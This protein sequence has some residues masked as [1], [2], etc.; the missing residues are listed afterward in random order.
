MPRTVHG[1]NQAH[2]IARENLQKHPIEHV[3]KS[4]LCFYKLTKSVITLQPSEIPHSF[5]MTKCQLLCIKCLT[6]SSSVRI[7]P[8]FLTHPKTSDVSNLISP[9]NLLIKTHLKL[10]MCM[11]RIS[12][13]V[14]DIYS[15]LAGTDKLWFVWSPIRQFRV[16]PIHKKNKTQE[17]LML[18]IMCQNVWSQIAL[19][20]ATK[21]HRKIK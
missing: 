10:S 19:L 14:R 16:D 20:C 21:T 1:L 12:T 17:T 11:Y 2:E 7:V 8:F 6:C 9:P 13:H 5:F 4:R 3:P 18:K 15:L